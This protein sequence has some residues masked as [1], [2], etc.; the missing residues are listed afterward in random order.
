MP[1]TVPDLAAEARQHRRLALAKLVPIFA[2]AFYVL[3]LA[4]N[5]ATL[6][7]NL[8]VLF[9][10]D[11]RHGGYNPMEPSRPIADRRTAAVAAEAR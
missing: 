8:S 5:A 6:Q 7:T 9:G 10:H 2:A 11:Q 3:L 1:P 4:W